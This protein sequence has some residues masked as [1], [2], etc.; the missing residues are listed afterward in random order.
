LGR[1]MFC[2]LFIYL[3]NTTTDCYT[4]RKRPFCNGPGVYS[5]LAFTSLAFATV[6]W[7]QH[8]SSTVKTS[9][10]ILFA[11]TATIAAAVVGVDKNNRRL[12]I[13]RRMIR[14]LLRYV[15]GAEEVRTIFKGRGRHEKEGM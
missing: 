10:R 13:R 12:L 14:S 2:F 8:T 6:E 7:D 15:Q 5:A 4:T 1:R 3:F 11:G 9:G